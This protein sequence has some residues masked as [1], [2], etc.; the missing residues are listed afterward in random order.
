[1][2]TILCTQC[3][4]LRV[5]RLQDIRA[6][7]VEIN[8]KKEYCNSEMV[9]DSCQNKQKNRAFCYFCSAIQRL[10]QCTECGRTKCMMADCTVSHLGKNAT[11]QLG[12]SFSH[13]L[14][15]CC[16]LVSYDQQQHTWDPEL[17]RSKAQQHLAKTYMATRFFVQAWAWLEQS[18]I[19]A[20]PGY[21][22]PRSAYRRRCCQV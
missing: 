17:L 9:C 20:R 4:I 14:H 19:F 5:V 1:M 2:G 8:L 15:Q 7:H 13:A 11:G 3:Q 6:G 22:I 21:A 18:V 12:K 16:D 10:P